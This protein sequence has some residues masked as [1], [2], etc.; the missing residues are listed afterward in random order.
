MFPVL[1]CAC[2]RNRQTQQKGKKKHHHD[3]ESKFFK[4]SNS[5]KVAKGLMRDKRPSVS[6]KGAG[7]LFEESFHMRSVQKLEAQRTSIDARVKEKIKKQKERLQAAG[8]AD[9][10]HEN[11]RR[12]EMNAVASTTNKMKMFWLNWEL[13]NSSSSSNAHRVMQCVRD[14]QSHALSIVRKFLQPEE[15]KS[16]TRLNIEFV[17]SSDIGILSSPCTIKAANTSIYGTSMDD[18]L[19][20]SRQQFQSLGSSSPTSIW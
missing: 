7:G 12:D 3:I 14:A 11:I 13:G 1:T 15:A 20:N 5:R 19:H 8:Y 16:S 10:E 18:T 17:L 4:S 2:G 6:S 9:F